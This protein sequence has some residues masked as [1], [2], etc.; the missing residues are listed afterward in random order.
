VNVVM[1]LPVLL[2]AERLFSH[3]SDV[4]F[5]AGVLRGIIIPHRIPVSTSYNLNFILK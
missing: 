1:N 4:A 5:I 3:L 2:R